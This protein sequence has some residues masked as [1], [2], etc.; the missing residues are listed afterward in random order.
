MNCLAWRCE[1]PRE[2]EHNVMNAT[3]ELVMLHSV[4]SCHAVTAFSDIRWWVINLGSSSAQHT[5][6]WQLLCRL[7]SHVS[8][9]RLECV[10]K[11]SM[12]HPQLVSLLHR[13]D[14]IKLGPL[15]P[16]RDSLA[17][18]SQLTLMLLWWG[19]KTLWCFTKHQVR[20]IKQLFIPRRCWILKLFNRFP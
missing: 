2:Q 11:R 7:V 17:G 13:Q 8:C 3:L 1:V 9:S 12:S 20:D 18:M 5:P 19:G 14:D 4:R 15:A 6:S 10:F 16:Q